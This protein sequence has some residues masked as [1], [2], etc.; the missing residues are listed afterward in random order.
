MYGKM[1]VLFPET[2]YFG[3]L[4]YSILLVTSALF[5]Y[6][7]T[8]VKSL[9]MPPVASGMFAISFIVISILFVAIGISSYYTRLYEVDEQD[10]SQTERIVLKHERV[11]WSLYLCMGIVYI[12]VQIGVCYYI[13]RGTMKTL[14][15]TR[16]SL[17]VM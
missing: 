15:E 13:V 9:E 2:L 3:A 1:N 5:F 10:L 17:I 12:L 11:Y 8:R 6:H 4:S 7:M 16:P 14:K